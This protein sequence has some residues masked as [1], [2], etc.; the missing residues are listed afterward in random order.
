MHLDLHHSGSTFNELGV[1][2]R[3]SH[4]RPSQGPCHNDRRRWRSLFAGGHAHDNGWVVYGLG[5]ALRLSHDESCA[6]RW[7]AEE[8]VAFQDGLKRYGANWRAIQRL[9]RAA[10]AALLFVMRLDVSRSK[11]PTQVPTRTLIQI[12]THAQKYFNKLGVGND[13]AG[14]LLPRTSDEE[15]ASPQSFAGPRGAQLSRGHSYRRLPL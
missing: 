5:M 12:R 14:G 8:H 2:L 10:N 13:P 15:L 4:N 7:S 3:G 9:V 11:L 6:G 1:D